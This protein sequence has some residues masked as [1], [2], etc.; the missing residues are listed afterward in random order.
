M[1]EH[2]PLKL[3]DWDPN[4]SHA[5]QLYC[6]WRK[7]PVPDEKAY[8]VILNTD[9]EIYYIPISTAADDIPYSTDMS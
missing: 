8:K 2:D 7:T 1:E 9:D 3:V 4:W 6:G 5:R